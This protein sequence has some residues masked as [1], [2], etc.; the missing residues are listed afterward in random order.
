VD[1]FIRATA[2]AARA[3][4]WY[5]FL[6]ALVVAELFAGRVL[7]RVVEASLKRP[8]LREIEAML[9]AP[10]GDPDLRLAFWDPQ[11]HRW[12]D[13]GTEFTQP[14]AGRA[15]TAVE[16]DGRPAVAIVHDAELAE[17]PELVHAAGAV[18]LLAHE[19]AELEQAWGESLDEL[20][21]SRARIVAAAEVERRALERDL[22]DGA[23]Q[24]L[25]AVLLSLS[26]VGEVLPEG[27]EA[28]VRLV[29]IEC[30]LEEALEELRRHAH[31]FY[32]IPLAETGI[33]G[34][35]EA[36]ATRS[37]GTIHVAVDGVGRYPPE[38]ESAVYYCCLEAV[39]N[40]TK[41]AGSGVGISIQL[42]E[43]N[44]EL[45]FEIRDD[46]PGFDL[47]AVHDGVGLR[48]MRDRVDALHG[49]IAVVTA[50]G[51]GSAVEG[52]IPVG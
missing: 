44:A 19:N 8:T 5:G 51:R 46:G 11:S 31:G 13:G 4:I 16:R 2:V 6:L 40:A 9:R 14:A 48:N 47:A 18:A 27:S 49:R 1:D 29:A 41:H 22:H 33:S 17:D 50:P 30:A 15:L 24:Q 32:P 37:G 35:L 36:V 21:E 28:K 45:R 7:R 25:T 34:A 26:R 12:G 38:V 43:S 42:R 20:R 23:Q 10:L 39:Q 52:A 3:A